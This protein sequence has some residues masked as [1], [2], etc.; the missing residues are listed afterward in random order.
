MISI[1]IHSY[2]NIPSSLNFS[3][4][5]LRIHSILSNSNEKNNFTQ[6]VAGLLSIIHCIATNIYNS[7]ITYPHL[8]PI[9]LMLFND[10]IVINPF[11][12]SIFIDWDE[13]ILENIISAPEFHCS[14]LKKVQFISLLQK[15]FL[16]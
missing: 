11:L 16:T 12:F 7:S 2:K 14:Y 9:G 5:I 1:K 4:D 15:N 13:E 3:E 10:R 6:T 8:R